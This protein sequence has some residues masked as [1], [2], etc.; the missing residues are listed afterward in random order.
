MTGELWPSSRVLSAEE[1]EGKEV[2]GE[3]VMENVEHLGQYVFDMTN[4]RI[5]QLRAERGLPED[6]AAAAAA[7]QEALP[8]PDEA[9]V[10]VVPEGEDAEEAVAEA[11]AEGF[12][13]E[14]D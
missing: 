5:K 12:E 6:V 3:T 13:A 2:A 11:Q 10:E 1:E 9:G 4:T 14:E 7:P 8:Q